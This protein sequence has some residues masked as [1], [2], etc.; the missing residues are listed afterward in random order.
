MLAT[1][2]GNGQEDGAERHGVN[3]KCVCR[4]KEFGQFSLSNLLF[5]VAVHEAYHAIS[6]LRLKPRCRPVFRQWR[7]MVHRNGYLSEA[8]REHRHLFGKKHPTLFQKPDVAREALNLR[9][10][11]A[12]EKDCGLW[13]PIQKALRS[14]HPVPTDPI[15]RTVRP[16]QSK[17]ADTRASLRRQPSCACRATDA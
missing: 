13:S 10:V 11:M 4:W 5:V 9:K 12:G 7:R 1:R 15:R 8:L 6:D 17:M 2:F 14:V 16:A 3:R